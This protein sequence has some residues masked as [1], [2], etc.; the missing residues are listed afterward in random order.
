MVSWRS[1]GLGRG[2]EDEDDGDDG[3]PVAPEG[4]GRDEDLRT[5]IRPVRSADRRGRGGPRS[6]AWEDFREDCREEDSMAEEAEVHSHTDDG[7]QGEGRGGRSRR[8]TDCGRRERDASGHYEHG[9]R[10]WEHD[11]RS[12]AD[13]EMILLRRDRDAD[14]D[15]V[16]APSRWDEEDRETPV[17]SNASAALGTA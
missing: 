6:D 11:G 10:H 7:E 17:E 9:H 4:T 1:P 3:L 8:A 5:E 14:A 16:D 15:A 13:R 2:R 12:S